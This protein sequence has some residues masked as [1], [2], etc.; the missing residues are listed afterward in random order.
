MRGGQ[1]RATASR[2]S[3]ADLEDFL[4]ALSLEG[5]SEHSV[6]SY[7]RDLV[8]LLAALPPRLDRVRAADLREHF[9]AQLATASLSA[10]RICLGH[11]RRHDR[12]GAPPPAST[13]PSPRRAPSSAFSSRREV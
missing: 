7:R 11:D 9:R 6:R 8:E 10:R 13:A 4:G 12:P 3:K 2:P 1:S 5:R